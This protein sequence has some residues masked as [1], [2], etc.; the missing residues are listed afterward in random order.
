MNVWISYNSIYI[1]VRY[2]NIHLLV[3]Q[4]QNS[5]HW[6]KNIGTTIVINSNYPIINIIGY[7]KYIKNSLH[8]LNS[9]SMYQIISLIE[10]A[11]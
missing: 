11:K 4:S 5:F 7:L 9:S 2:G 6:H 1:S 3:S 8:L 10:N